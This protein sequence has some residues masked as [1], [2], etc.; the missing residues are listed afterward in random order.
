MDA[1][2]ELRELARSAPAKLIVRIKS[3][4]MTPGLLTRAAEALGLSS[5]PADHELVVPVLLELL[6]HD[7]AVV[8]EGA[9]YGLGSHMSP[10]V[11][12]ALRAKVRSEG[13][14]PVIREVVSE[15]L[16]DDDDVKALKDKLRKT[17]EV[18]RLA[19]AALPKCHECESYASGTQPPLATHSR[20][21]S[22][23]DVIPTC[24]A[25]ARI[26]GMLGDEGPFTR[27]NI[28]RLKALLT[29]L[30]F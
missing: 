15:M 17:E 27:K 23:G 5:D 28:A 21:D 24:E 2:R 26:G 10:R 14:H 30:G 11:R 18:L 22:V 3:G 6:D 16:M 8:Q 12:C 13:T 1:E 20:L 19:V 7:A 29:E 4:E 9:A 25:H